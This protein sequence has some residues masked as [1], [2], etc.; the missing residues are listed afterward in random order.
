MRKQ[1]ANVNNYVINDGKSWI[2]REVEVQHI[3]DQLQKISEEITK[4]GMVGSNERDRP[5]QNWAKNGD[6]NVKD[7]IRLLQA[8][9]EIYDQDLWK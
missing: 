7:A 1:G 2:F 8:E 3:K 9:D 5:K 4:K 6:Y